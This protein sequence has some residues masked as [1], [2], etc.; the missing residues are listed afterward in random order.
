MA[1]PD[2]YRKLLDRIAYYD[3]FEPRYD[4]DGNLED[5]NAKEILAMRLCIRQMLWD[6][7]KPN[8]MGEPNYGLFCM[9]VDAMIE[10]K[11]NKEL[12]REEVLKELKRDIE[13]CEIQERNR[14]RRNPFLRIKKWIK[15]TKGD[16]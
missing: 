5:S 14:I 3:S 13:I 4:K 12:K 1:I 15:S 16:E 7:G 2:K 11:N 9:L 10:D 6:L 8:N